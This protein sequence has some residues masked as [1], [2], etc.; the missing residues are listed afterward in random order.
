MSPPPTPHSLPSPPPKLRKL[1]P[2]LVMYTLRCRD[3][4]NST[5]SERL[6]CHEA[7]VK[8]SLHANILGSITQPFACLGNIASGTRFLLGMTVPNVARLF[9]WSFLNKDT[10]VKYRSH[11]MLGF[12]LFNG[13]TSHLLDNLGNRIQCRCISFLSKV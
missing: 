9:L 7:I 6:G 4:N 11:V 10:L 13:S 5:C 3:G 8:L 12:Y 2:P 1:D